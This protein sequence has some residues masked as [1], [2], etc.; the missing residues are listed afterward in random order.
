MSGY[1][2][3]RNGPKQTA[4][5]F[6]KAAG[7]NACSR[8]SPFSSQGSASAMGAN[9][10]TTGRR[11]AEL[12]KSST[13][14]QWLASVRVC[15]DRMPVRA[16]KGV[17]ADADLAPRAAARRAQQIDD[18]V[19]LRRARACWATACFRIRPGTYLLQL[20]AASLRGRQKLKLAEVATDVPARHF[21][22]WATLL[23]E[24]ALIC[25]DVGPLVPSMFWVGLRR[26]GAAR[27]SELFASLRT[28][29]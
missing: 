2:R 24:R 15:P 18:I 17:W 8:I 26:S 10:L 12:M 13:A 4:I 25:C 22:R 11:R 29:A 7:L 6:R 14:L 19:R 23:E 1:F 9:M 3:L 20:Y 28:A 21:A 16:R 27:M 5:V